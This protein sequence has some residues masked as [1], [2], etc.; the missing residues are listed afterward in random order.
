MGAVEKLKGAFSLV[1]L[2]EDH[3]VGVRDP[4]GW[5]PLSLGKLNGSWV[6][7]SETCAFDLIGAEFVRDVEPGEAVLINKNGIESHFPFDK[8]IKTSNCIFEYIY[9][10]RPD[11]RVFGKNVALIR[12]RLGEE[13]AKSHPVE[14][15]IVIQFLTPE[16]LLH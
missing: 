15:D 3:L 2:T 14:A 16:T 11:S 9:F 4:H 13:L 10:A 7:S 1:F 12:Q 5:R 8:E 6:L